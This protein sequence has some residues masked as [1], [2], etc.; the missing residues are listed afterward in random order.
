LGVADRPTL[1]V[2]NKADLLSAE[3]SKIFARNSVRSI[4]AP[5]LV[6]ALTGFGLDELLRRIDLAVPIDPMMS[7]SLRLPLAEGR[8]LALVHALGRVLHS[9]VED[10][11]MLIDAEVPDSIVRRLR[12]VQYSVNGTSRTVLT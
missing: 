10:A 4:A 6:S 5:V 8:T 11:H 7:M 2:L 3:D 1:R 12:L 9:Q